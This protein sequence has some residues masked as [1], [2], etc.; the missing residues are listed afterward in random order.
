MFRLSNVNNPF[1]PKQGQAEEKC[2]LQNAAKTAAKGGLYT[3]FGLQQS[4]R[5]E[6]RKSSNGIERNSK[7]KLKSFDTKLYSAVI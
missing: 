4:I 6:M 3:A 2:L 7:P 1:G 5:Y